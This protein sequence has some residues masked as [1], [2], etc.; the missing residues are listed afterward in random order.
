MKSG[1]LLLAGVFF[2][3]G[4]S[5]TSPQADGQAEKPTW[6]PK[7]EAA[8]R[9][10]K[11][12]MDVTLTVHKVYVEHVTRVILRK[13]DSGIKSNFDFAVA[14]NTIPSPDTLVKFIGQT[15]AA[16]GR[17]AN[18]RM[19]SEFPFAHR[20]GT[21]EAVLDDQEKAALEVF[22]RD[23]SAADWKAV[24]TKGGIRVVRYFVPRKMSKGCVDCHNNR[25]DSSKKDWKVGDAG[26]AFEAVV[27][28]E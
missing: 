25:A 2:G 14:E 7:E 15:L 11:A 3:I 16:E 1:A 13:P 6:G 23:A 26:G 9:A 4:L 27:P 10:A 21:P 5:M 22:R 8:L 28:I 20:V 12:L 24:S 17:G 18:M 19:Y